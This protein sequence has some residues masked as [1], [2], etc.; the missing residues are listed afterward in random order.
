MSA[1]PTVGATPR[2]AAAARA[3][4]GSWRAPRGCVVATRADEAGTGDTLGARPMLV[5]RWT[6]TDGAE[7][8][9]VAVMGIAGMV[10]P[11]ATASRNAGRKAARGSIRRIELFPPYECVE[12]H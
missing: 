2:R 9:A 3:L 5:A 6:A 12:P 1:E 10:K 4:L 8:A 11:V 7:P